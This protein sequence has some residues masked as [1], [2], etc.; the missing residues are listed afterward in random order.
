MFGNSAVTAGKVHIIKNAIELDNFSPNPEIR[1]RKRSELGVKDNQL[2][3]GQV[4]RMCFQKNQMFTVDIFMEV[5]KH[6]S[7]AKLVFVGGGELLDAVR[8][9]VQ[10]LRLERSVQFLGM[11]NDMSELYQAFD[12]LAFPSTYEGLG[13][14]AIEAQAT[15]LMVI[16]SDQ[17]PSEARIVPGLVNTMKLT[18]P[19]K[20]WANI[21]LRSGLTSSPTNVASRTRLIDAGYEIQNSANGLCQWYTSIYADKC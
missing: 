17:V 10:R 14:A 4:G 21:L 12:V 15:G 13:M 1:A 2:V 9:K 20:D 11:R 6:R 7:D 19:A 16:A 18:Q 3:I 5:L 8:A